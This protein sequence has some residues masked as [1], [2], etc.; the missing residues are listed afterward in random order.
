MTATAVRR[1]ERRDFDPLAKVWRDAWHMAHAP[2][3]PPA[4]TAMRTPDSFAERLAGLGNAVRTIGP[5]GAPVGLC[6]IEA[7]Q[8]YQ[9]YVARQAQGTGAADALLRDGEQRLA[10][11]GVDEAWL[12]CVIENTRA[13][14]FY[15]RNGWV[16]SGTD[17][18]MLAGTDGGF[19][20]NVRIFR[21]NLK[22]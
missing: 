12:D 11:S 22:S 18:V 16:D 6:A 10:A 15:T 5:V 2:W 17:T 13:I 8:L 21:K 1:V 9:I 20:L 3:V 7:D 19:P 14:R 4:L